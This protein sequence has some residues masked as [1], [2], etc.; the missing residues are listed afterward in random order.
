LSIFT[1]LLAL[2]LSLFAGRLLGL[3]AHPTL[4]PGPV[5]IILSVFALAL[6]NLFLFQTIPGLMGKVCFVV[7]FVVLVAAL[8]IGY[9]SYASTPPYMIE[10]HAST[11]TAADI[12]GTAGHVDG[13]RHVVV[14]KN[15]L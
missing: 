5:G 7:T 14:L 11:L 9:R 12:R 1:G 10:R 8:A 2:W 6:V 15:G 4:L 13:S 3:A